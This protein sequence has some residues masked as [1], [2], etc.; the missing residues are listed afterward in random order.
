MME[1]ANH[2]AVSIGEAAGDFYSFTKA[3][4]QDAQG[5]LY[6]IMSAQVTPLLFQYA[7]SPLE[8]RDFAPD[9]WSLELA[10]EAQAAASIWF[11]PTKAQPEMPKAD[12]NVILGV[13]GDDPLP[14]FAAMGLSRLPEEEVK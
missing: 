14:I 8:R 12:P 3:D 2:L 9:D 6:A 1:R 11:G 5:N 10:T 13:V 4:W 7:V